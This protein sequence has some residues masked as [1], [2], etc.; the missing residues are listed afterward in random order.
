MMGSLL[1]EGEDHVRAP[2]SESPSDIHDDHPVRSN[3]EDAVLC[4]R[5][6]SIDKNR[7][8]VNLLKKDLWES[9]EKSKGT[10]LNPG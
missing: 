1:L 9:G 3:N 4:D 2:Q 8:M 6:R 7:C 10:D 5:N